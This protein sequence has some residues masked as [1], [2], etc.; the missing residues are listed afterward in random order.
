MGRRDPS[1]YPIL[2]S[3]GNVLLY[4]LLY[5]LKS[6]PRLNLQ[7]CFLIYVCFVTGANR[8]Q[9]SAT[10][11]SAPVWKEYCNFIRFSV[12]QKM[13]VD[14]S[15]IVLNWDCYFLLLLLN[16][17]FFFFTVCNLA[18][19]YIICYLMACSHCDNL[20]HMVWQHASVLEDVLFL[21]Q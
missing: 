10:K 1:V 3:S 17:F 19:M 4:L 2:E 12:G 21:G 13:L 20:H 11:C 14:V 15:L 6:F 7:E 8:P 5:G 9:P 16:F 18:E